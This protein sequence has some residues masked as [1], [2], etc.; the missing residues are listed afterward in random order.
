MASIFSCKVEAKGDWATKLYEKI[1]NNSIEQLK[2][3]L[4]QGPKSVENTD[5]DFLSV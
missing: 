2:N 3:T 1:H 5:L 4:T